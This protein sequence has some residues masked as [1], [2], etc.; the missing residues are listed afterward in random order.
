[1]G[2]VIIQGIFEKNLLKMGPKNQFNLYT[3]GLAETEL[4]SISLTHFN[5]HFMGI[6]F[7]VYLGSRETE[8]GEGDGTKYLGDGCDRDGG[9]VVVTEALCWLRW[10]WTMGCVRVV[11]QRREIEREKSCRSR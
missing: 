9:A 2:I 11:L 5:K 3:G 1:M 10:R 8:R 4:G 7:C 6:V